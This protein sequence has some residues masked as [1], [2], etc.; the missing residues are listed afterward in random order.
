MHLCRIPG[1]CSSCLLV[2]P[3]CCRKCI[4]MLTESHLILEFEDGDGLDEG[5]NASHQKKRRDSLHDDEVQDFDQKMLTNKAMR[6]KAIRWNIS[7]AS[8]RIESRGRRYGR[9]WCSGWGG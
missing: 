1:Y 6:P 8:E 4:V 3:D 7:E 9:R 2:K 5:D